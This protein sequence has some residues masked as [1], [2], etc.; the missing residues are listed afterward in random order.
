MEP[1][2]LFAL[3]VLTQILASISLFFKAEAIRGLGRVAGGISITAMSYFAYLQFVSGTGLV[4]AIALA[5]CGLVTIASGARKFARR[6]L[7]Q[8]G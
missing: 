8:S 6:N 4:L 3:V 2:P 7:E 5:V 1:I